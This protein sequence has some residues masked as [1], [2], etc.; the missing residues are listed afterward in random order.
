MKKDSIE[1]EYR[2]STGDKEGICIFA[3]GNIRKRNDFGDLRLTL[4]YILK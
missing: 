3:W 1:G 2:T 4:K